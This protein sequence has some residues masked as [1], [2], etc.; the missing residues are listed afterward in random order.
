MKRWKAG[1]VVAMAIVLAVVACAPQVYEGSESSSGSASEGVLTLMVPS[2]APKFARAVGAN[3]QG[4]LSPQAIIIVSRV[5]FDLYLDGVYTDTVSVEVGTGPDGGGDTVYSWSV[6][7][8][9]GYHLTARVYNTNVSAD[10][11]ILFGESAPFDVTAGADTEVWIAPT[12][13]PAGVLTIDPTD[14]PEGLPAVAITINSCYDTGTTD[15]DGYPIY[16]WEDEHW[17]VI[18]A[19]GETA[20]QVIADPDASSGVYMGIFDSEGFWA[21]DALSGAMGDDGPAYWGFGAPATTAFLAPGSTYYVGLITI[22]DTVGSS[23]VS[24]VDLHWNSFSDDPYEENDS[25]SAAAPIE[26]AEVLSGIDLDYAEDHF[27]SRI[28]GD[29]YSFVLEASDDPNVTVVLE[30]DHDATDL[31]LGLYSWSG[32][33]GEDPTQIGLSSTSAL[34]GP[35]SPGDLEEE[36]IEQSL[37]AGTYYLW[38]HGAEG[39]TPP[40]GASYSLQWVA[41][42]GSIL[43]GLE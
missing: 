40:K 31:D 12:P 13:D 8:A 36:R 3:P 33:I 34:S 10:T 18:D 29:W 30:F 35:V 39:W 41:G 19:T 5:E 21:G 4:E 20:V 16:G 2:V 6:P 28:G 32:T 43:I 22:S 15:P 7:A 23:V 38:V 37:S 42:E 24:T 17:F 26:Q 25:V 1:T 14:A 27:G 9:S 11:P